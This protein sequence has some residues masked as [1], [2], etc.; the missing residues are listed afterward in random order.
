MT[1]MMTQQ[2]TDLIKE[3]ILNLGCNRKNECKQESLQIMDFSITDDEEFNGFT[4][5]CFTSS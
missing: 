3:S 5:N 1:K 2:V 4:E